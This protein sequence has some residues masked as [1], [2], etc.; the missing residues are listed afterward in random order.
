MAKPFS[1]II[2]PKARSTRKPRKTGLTIVVDF[3]MTLPQQR[4]MLEM[5]A[6]YEL[7]P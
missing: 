5:S 3:G 1:F 7:L 6:D 2:F 4:G